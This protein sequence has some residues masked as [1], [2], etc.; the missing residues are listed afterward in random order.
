MSSRRS[1]Q[2][3][4]GQRA[5]NRSR[6]SRHSSRASNGSSQERNSRNRDTRRMPPIPDFGNT[7]EAVRPSLQN[8]LEPHPMQQGST[9]VTASD[10][11]RMF[12]EAP[13]LPPLRASG[14]SRRERGRH[15]SSR[16][17]A[18]SNARDS[19]S[20]SSRHTASSTG[21]R[22]RHASTSGADAIPPRWTRSP[23]PD[24]PILPKLRMSPEEV[25]AREAS[26][27]TRKSAADSDTGGE[28]TEK[29]P[30]FKELFGK[31]SSEK[32]RTRSPA[33]RAQAEDQNR[34]KRKYTECAR[35]DRTFD[36]KESANKH[37]RSCTV[38]HTCADC[39]YS[40]PYAKFAAR[41][42]AKHSERVCAHC[43]AS[44]NTYETYRSH[45]DVNHSRPERFA[46]RYC[47]KV[48]DNRSSFGYHM[49]ARHA[50]QGDFECK[51]CGRRF[52]TKNGMLIHIGE[53]HAEP[54]DKIVCDI[55]DREFA[56]PSNLKRHKRQ[57]H[58]SWTGL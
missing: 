35:C 5:P 14:R 33:A 51:H 21:R 58:R 32:E 22:E 17:A 52:A 23:S 30:G 10:I 34:G 42:R 38:T 7:T 55:C 9:H 56:N 49:R 15:A 31:R 41:H 46:C 28:A 53:A 29:L 45:M 18:P 11:E 4:N 26:R 6:D 57:V 54:G 43:K 27:T 2:H 36:N 47:G 24:L 19:R 3:N 40:T 8:V 20:S 16:S 44:F 50:D 13:P 1:R 39:D 48:Y 12:R 37:R 25:R